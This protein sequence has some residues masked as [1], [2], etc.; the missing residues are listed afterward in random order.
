VSTISLAEW[1]DAERRRSDEEAA[2]VTEEELQ[3]SERDFA[4]YEDPRA[5][6]VYPLEYVYH[7]VGPVRGLS[8]LD[9]GCGSGMHTLY[10]KRKGAHVHS[11]DLSWSLLRVTRRRLAV[12]SAGRGSLTQA[13]AHALP[14]KGES[15][16]IV[17]GNAI[18]HHLN[19]S[20][21]ATELHR[22][23]KPAGKAIFQE[24]MRNSRLMRFLRGWLAYNADP[25]SP[26]ERPLTQQDL[27]PLLDAFELRRFRM[28]S[29]PHVRIAHLFKPG[30]RLQTFYH[31]DGWL[32]RNAP[33][34]SRYASIAVFELVKGALCRRE[35]DEVRPSYCTAR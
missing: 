17:F 10:L 29:L 23:L 32:L 18:L 15:F 12:R 20:V 14:F 4:R 31:W 2:A 34:L 35:G 11:L 30:G 21:A 27:D 5:E 6:A 16:D 1:E 26:Y 9:L 24:P 25:V 3:Q 22:V 8:V 28:F 13:S 33:F 7:L 19:P